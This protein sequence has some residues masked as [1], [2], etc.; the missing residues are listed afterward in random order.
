MN[1][2]GKAHMARILLL[3]DNRNMLDAFAEALKHHEHDVATAINGRKG[4]DIIETGE[5]LPKIIIT[6]L[7]MPQVSGE[8]ILRVVKTSP[9][10]QHIAVIVMS[11]SPIDEQKVLSAGADAFILKP[12]KHAELEEIIRRLDQE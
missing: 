9:Q 12:F 2:K 5:F 8:E 11:G 10:F 4:L 1:P 6:D 3:E 7:K